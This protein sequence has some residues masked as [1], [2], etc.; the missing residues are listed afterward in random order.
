MSFVVI[1]KFKDTDGHIYDVNNPYPV[2]GKATKK[3]LEE[4]L[5]V[6]SKYKVAFIR[7]VEEQEDDTKKEESPSKK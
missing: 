6:H 5:K 4:L 7:E 1:N 2:K 3:R